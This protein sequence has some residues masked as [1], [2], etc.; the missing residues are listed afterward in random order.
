MSIEADARSYAGQPPPDLDSDL[1]RI[2]EEHSRDA[3][4][5]VAAYRHA[6]RQ[7]AK[8]RNLTDEY[9]R[10]V[11]DKTLAAAA[12]SPAAQTLAAFERRLPAERYS[13]RVWSGGKTDRSTRVIVL[14]ELADEAAERLK[15]ELLGLQR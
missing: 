4:A 15:V 14:E 9:A 7:A 5:R 12:T 3:R 2:L 1:H 6:L 8:N 11:A 10:T 13:A